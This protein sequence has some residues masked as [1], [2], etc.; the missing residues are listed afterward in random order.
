MPDSMTVACWNCGASNAEQA[1]FCRGCGM[2]LQ[3]R[4]PGCRAPIGSRQNFCGACGTQLT[5][6][7]SR[8]Q[9]PEHLASRISPAQAERKIATLLFADITNSTAIIRDLD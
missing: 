5:H 6:G 9:P 1:H 7:V 2:S 8:F 3:E 4:C